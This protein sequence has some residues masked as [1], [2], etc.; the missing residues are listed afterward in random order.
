MT[1][2]KER[3]HGGSEAYD[4]DLTLWSARQA[5]LLRA[6]EVTTLDWENLAEEIESLGKSDLHELESRLLILL[7]HL[8][9]L[10]HGLRSEPRAGWK[11]TVLEQ[12]Q[13]IDRV[14]KS[15]PSLRPR[16]SDLAT[17]VFSD[18]RETALASFEEHEPD[19]LGNYASELPRQLP[20]ARDALL[21]RTFIPGPDTAA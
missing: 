11:R 1:V 15:S 12:R 20:Y 17:E 16:L 8:L 7:E 13:R 5:A 10:D 19:N 9:K 6:R 21:D 18:A 14:L 4:T 3:T 2:L